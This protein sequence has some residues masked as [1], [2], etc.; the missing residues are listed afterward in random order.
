MAGRLDQRIT[1]ALING[2]I[3]TIDNDVKR[4]LLDHILILYRVSKGEVAIDSESQKSYISSILYLYLPQKL[5]IHR[6]LR[7][8]AIKQRCEGNL[9]N[10]D[11]YIQ[12]ARYFWQNFICRDSR[13]VDK[14]LTHYS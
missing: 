8:E 4:N 12:V 1:K 10:G 2:T 11:Y 6:E 9:K 7:K 3:Q 14:S 5:L 13:K